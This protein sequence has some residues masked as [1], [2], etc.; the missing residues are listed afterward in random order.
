MENRVAPEPSPARLRAVLRLRPLFIA[1]GMA[2]LASTALGDFVKARAIEMPG[3]IGLSFEGETAAASFKK[4]ETGASCTAAV[5]DFG[6]GGA[7]VIT[8]KHCLGG[9]ITVFDEAHSL[10]VSGQNEAKGEIDLA[11]LETERPLPFTS[12]RPRPTKTLEE[13]ERLCAQRV[14]RGFGKLGRQTVCGRF[15]GFVERG[16]APPLLRVR[17][18]FP[19]GASGSPL[20]DHAGRVVGIVVASEGESGLAEPIEAA[21]SLTR[22]QGPT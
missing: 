19:R 10:E 16:D 14:E 20:V 22:P 12:L 11:L 21:A 4:R 5:V 7:V 13:G 9:E 1:L 8:A 17:T 18:P 2:T 6:E 3:I 15:G